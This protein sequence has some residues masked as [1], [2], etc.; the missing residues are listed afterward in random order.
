MSASESGAER[1]KV[2]TK[3][4]WLRLAELEQS[5]LVIRDALD[6]LEVNRVHQMLPLSGQLRALLVEKRRENPPLLIELAAALGVDIRLFAGPEIGNDATDQEM[7]LD[8]GGTPLSSERLSADQDE[9]S[10]EQFLSRRMLRVKGTSYSIAQIIKL[11]AEKAGGAHHP[12]NVPED[13]LELLTFRSS[14]F[15]PL[16]MALMSIGRAVLRIGRDLIRRICDLDLHVIVILPTQRTSSICLLD[17][18]DPATGAKITLAVDALGRVS[19]TV[20]AVDGWAWQV[21]SETIV[22]PMQPLHILFSARL[23]TRLETEASI[24]VDG[25]LA[26]RVTYQR[27]TMMSDFAQ[28][29]EIVC[30]RA[31][32]NSTLTGEFGLATMSIVAAGQNAYD[33]ADLLHEMKER[34]ESDRWLLFL[35][36]DTLQFST[37]A[38]AVPPPPPD[39]ATVVHAPDRYSLAELRDRWK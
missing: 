34:R 24:H 25:Q 28:D 20:V 14:G 8:V 2:L 5:L 31:F 6:G 37:R 16:P 39:G 26:A 12:R 13:I 11:A 15:R 33:D 10:V 29:Y 27:P 32:D 3:P 17:A 4:D 18:H 19:V 9:L 21:H 22:A 35:A 1:P 23:T 30:N 7:L 36:G 38:K